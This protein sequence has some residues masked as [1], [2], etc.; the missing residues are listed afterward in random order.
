MNQLER[1]SGNSLEIE[2]ARDAL[3]GKMETDVKEVVLELVSYILKLA[4]KGDDLEENKKKAIENIENRKSLWKIFTAYRKTKWGYKLFK[5]YP[6]GKI[7]KR[8][9]GRQS[10]ICGKPRCWNLS[11]GF[12]SRLVHGRETKEDD[13]DHLARY[14]IGKENWRQSRKRWSPCIYTY[15]YARE[16]RDSRDKAKR[17]I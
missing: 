6:K 14:S 10:G 3:N 1:K 9:S 7:H 12:R 17:S 2:E 4:G 13:I 16:N 11:E 8:S 15:E 5:Q